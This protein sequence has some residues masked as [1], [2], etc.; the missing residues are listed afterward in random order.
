MKQPS[1]TQILATARK[2]AVIAAHRAALRPHVLASHDLRTALAALKRNAPKGAT[3]SMT[4]SDYA[5]TVYLS[6]TIRNLNSLKDKALAKAL[7]PFAGDEAWRASTNDYTYGDEPNRD[8]TFERS[9]V[10]DT[11]RTASARWLQRNA[12]Q[13]AYM[14]F[15]IFLRIGAY[16]KPDSDACRYEMDVVEE[17]VRKETK[18]IVC[19]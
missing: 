9:A 14:H 10:I 12:H 2:E 15:S 8:F 6:L 5:H 3:V 19:A 16:V 13:G 17:V 11:P 18:R 4:V 1:I 7:A